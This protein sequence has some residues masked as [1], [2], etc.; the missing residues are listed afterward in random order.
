VGYRLQV[1][2]AIFAMLFSSL[3]SE[4]TTINKFRIWTVGG[5][6]QVDVPENEQIR[7]INPETGVTYAARRYGVDANLS[8]LTSANPMN[9]RQIDRGIASRMI[10]HANELLAGAFRVQSTNADGTHVMARD[11]AGALIPVDAN[12]Q[13]RA[14]AITAYRNYVGLVD[15]V[16]NISNILGYGLLR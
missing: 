7:F 9:Q 1:P 5:G 3:N 12:L 8:G 11:S 6:E 14:R 15:A 16:R 4:L 13:V 2:T 10:A